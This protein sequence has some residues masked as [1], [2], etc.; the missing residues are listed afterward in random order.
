MGEG[1]VACEVDGAISE[2][3]GALCDDVHVNLEGAALASGIIAD[4]AFDG[5]GVSTLTMSGQASAGSGLRDLD[6]RAY[7]P[8]DEGEILRLNQAVFGTARTRDDWRWQN[9]ESPAGPSAI[10]LAYDA[11]RLVGHLALEPRRARVVGVERMVAQAVDGMVAP[12][13]RRRGVF[14][15]VATRALALA[16]ARRVD[17]VVG[18]PNQD[19][20][21]ALLRLGFETRLTLHRRVLVWSPVRLV[22][23]LSSRGRASAVEVRWEPRE[24]DPKAWASRVD[25]LGAASMMHMD[26][27]LERT[28]R[29][30]LHRYGARPDARYRLVTGRSAA[31]VVAHQLVGA[32]RTVHVC[33]L[34]TEDVSSMRETAFLLLGVLR[35]AWRS[36]AGAVSCRCVRGS[37]LDRALRILG[38]AKAHGEF[39]VMFL[40]LTDDPI[41]PIQP[42][43]AFVT[44]GDFDIV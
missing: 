11:S 35:H 27:A 28:S 44:A 32:S 12:E 23:R 3:E 2:A 14:L 1:N 42:E 18:I 20:R 26:Y 10:A 15:A 31:A 13:E 33:D 40:S 9:V 7:Q 24:G 37:V 19:S 39:P 17:V 29:A 6:V 34:V 25:D 38:F 22:R 30:W 21:G 4:C 8:D 41:P 5:A 36:G 43:K 16:C